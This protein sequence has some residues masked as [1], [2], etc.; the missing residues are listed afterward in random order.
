MNKI[1]APDNN[2]MMV[3]LEASI[4]DSPKANRHRTEL[5]AKAIKARLVRVNVFI[6]GFLSISSFHQSDQGSILD[7]DSCRIAR[8]DKENRPKS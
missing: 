1:A 7:D 5:A 6:R 4:L 2:L 8:Q 3:K